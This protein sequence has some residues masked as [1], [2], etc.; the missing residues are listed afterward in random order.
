MA[1]IYT[2]P[3]K[4]TPVNDDLI[5]ISDSADSNKTKNITV[6]SLV[7]L[8]SG[9]TSFSAGSTGLTP[10]SASTGVIT[11]AGTLVVGNGG[12]GATTLAS[13]GALKGN[14]AGAVTADAGLTNLAD[15]FVNAEQTHYGFYLGNIPTNASAGTTSGNIALG[16]D[17]LENIASGGE[18][19]IAIGGDALKS[20]TTGDQNIG[21]GTD[22]GDTNET[23]TGNILIGNTADV[24]SSSAAGGI[25][26]G[27][28]AVVTS[29][30]LAIGRGAS[31]TAANAIALGRGATTTAAN[32]ALGSASY[33]LNNTTDSGDVGS[34]SKWIEVQIGATKYWMAL[35]TQN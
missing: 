8:G 21:I 19:N 16:T 30:A 23:G 32:L 9:V 20:N 1:I 28:A 4:T 33:P 11:L 15:C 18:N 25:G 13:G 14:G 5:L 29:S 35:Y 17:A 10:S 27:D 7:A 34:A 3:T 26:I 24:N 6:S 2:Y 12:T 22:A 31:A